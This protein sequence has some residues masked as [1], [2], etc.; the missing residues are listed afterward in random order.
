[1]GWLNDQLESRCVKQNK[2]D[3]GRTSFGGQGGKLFS[4][5]R[6][7]CVCDRIFRASAYY[8]SFWIYVF[9]AKNWVGNITSRNS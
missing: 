6:G 5:Q 1:M 7:V 4:V 2:K 8:V 9:L 3:I